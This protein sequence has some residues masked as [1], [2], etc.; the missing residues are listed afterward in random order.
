MCIEGLSRYLIVGAYILE[1]TKD[2]QSELNRVINTEVRD[3]IMPLLKSPGVRG[4]AISPC[5]HPARFEPCLRVIGGNLL[6][7]WCFS[8]SLDF[9]VIKREG[10]G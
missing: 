9:T 1:D 8:P 2:Q 3:Q 7:T 4:F 5:Y 10:S 6:A